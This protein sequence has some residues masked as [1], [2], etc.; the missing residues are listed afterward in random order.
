MPSNYEKI[1]EENLKEY[2]AGT[3]HLAFFEKIYPEHT[4]SL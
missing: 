4:L 3:R 2:G 1:K